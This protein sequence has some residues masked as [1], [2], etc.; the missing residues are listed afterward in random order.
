ME[1]YTAVY[2]GNFHTHE[3]TQNFTSTEI[4]LHLKPICKFFLLTYFSFTVS[5]F[6]IKVNGVLQLEHEFKSIPHYMNA[7]ENAFPS[8]L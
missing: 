5:G 8:I 6:S 7:E 3:L 1:I 4:I 2:L